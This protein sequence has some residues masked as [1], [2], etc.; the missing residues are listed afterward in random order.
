VIPGA[1]AAIRPLDVA[2]IVLVAIAVIG[3]LG[4]AVFAMLRRRA[5]SGLPPATAIRRAGSYAALAL[6]LLVAARGGVPGVAILVGGLAAI[7]L[8]EWSAMFDLPIHHRVSLLIADAVLVVA[9]GLEGVAAADRLVG[10]L[11]LLGAAWPV[12][13]VDTGRA[14]RDLG[15]A[16][17]GFVLIPVML[18]HGLA[19]AVEGG[20]AGIVL[21][22][23]LAVS[24]AGS[25]VGAFV[26]GRRF[27]RTP[28]SVRLSPSKTRAGVVGNIL[29]GAAGLAPFVPALTPSFPPAFLVALVPLVAVGAVWGDLLESAIKRELGVKDA[30]AWLPG[31]GGILDRIDSLLITVALAYWAWRIVGP[32]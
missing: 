13:R 22:V 23:A 7:G 16:A 25:D 19:L 27:G 6:L 18:V 2:S 8:L 32:G 4:A 24:C 15:A 21:F 11:V 31:F 12:L 5:Q 9:I 1:L 20:E 10:G 3:L 26:V 14:V 30:A 17:V 29:G 28:L